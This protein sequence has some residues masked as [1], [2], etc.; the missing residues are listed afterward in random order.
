[1]P[2]ETMPPEGWLAKEGEAEW[3]PEWFDDID[4]ETRTVLCHV[5]GNELGVLRYFYYVE[6]PHN[7][8]RPIGFTMKVAANGTIS[9][10]LTNPDD[11]LVFINS[12]HEN[13]V[14]PKEEL[15]QVP[16]LHALRVKSS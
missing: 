2:D 6:D 1:M 9:F 5:D 8:G 14:I 13:P 12:K 4:H 16:N 7:L 11:M 10:E 3:G 15:K